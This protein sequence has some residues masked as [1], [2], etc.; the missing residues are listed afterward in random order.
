MTKFRSRA[1]GARAAFYMRGSEGQR[2]RLPKL[3]PKEYLEYQI[4]IEQGRDGENP[5]TA[6]S[7]AGQPQGA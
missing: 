5:V 3:E 4:Q 2:R 6:T 1:I 7:A